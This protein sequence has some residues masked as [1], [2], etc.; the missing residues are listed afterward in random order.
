MWIFSSEKIRKRAATSEPILPDY[1]GKETLV[2]TVQGAIAFEYS[3]LDKH[4]KNQKDYPV[5]KIELHLDALIT[6]VVVFVLAISFLLYQRHQYSDV[7]Q[8]NIDLTWENEKLNV[9]LI[10]ETSLLDK[11]E[12]EKKSE[13][14]IT[15][16]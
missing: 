16:N 11:C 1:Y 9:N 4:T 6:I 7:L 15:V 13:K 14:E 2:R 12:N 3:E 10:W 8:E 5:K